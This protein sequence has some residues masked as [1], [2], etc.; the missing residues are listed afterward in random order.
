MQTFS[1]TQLKLS[2]V[3]GFIVLGFLESSWAPM[4][5]YV[6]ARFALDEFNL[7]LL[8]IWTGI[9]SFTSLPVV[10]MLVGRWGCRTVVM[11]SAFIMALSLVLLSFVSNLYACALLL[12]LFGASTI[13]VDVAVN[14]NS[15]IVED[16]LKRPLM[17]GF[18]GGY[19][20]GALL[21]SAILSFMLTLGIALLT[22]VSLFFV[23]MMATLLFGC[24]Q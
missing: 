8:L 19:S 3:I 16:R 20:M 15:V 9:G 24:R 18:H 10:S 6:K 23:I 22:D 11:L 4:V 2:C 14:V 21:G 17:S 13:G 5:P 1:H 7:G 12:F